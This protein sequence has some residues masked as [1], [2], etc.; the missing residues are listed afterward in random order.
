MRKITKENDVLLIVDEVMTG[1]GRTG[2]WFAVNLWGVEPDILTTAKGASASYVPIGITAVSK[3]IADFFEDKMFPH[4]HTFEAHPVSLAAIPAVVEEYKRMNLL[5]HVKVMG[6]YLG[7]RLKELKERHKSV[8]DVRGVGFFWAIELVKDSR[9]TP[10]ATYEDKYEGKTT[11]TDY[12]AKRLLDM[13]VYVFNGPS[14]FVIAPPLIAQ[15][16]DIDVGVNALDEVLKEADK[17]YRG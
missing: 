2:E 11:F 5:A 17:E 16:E 3:E 1:W 15:K 4:G 7:E 8:G 14:W 6:N 10:F 13:G 12:L 9:N